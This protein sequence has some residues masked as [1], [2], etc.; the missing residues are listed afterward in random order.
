MPGY[1]PFGLVLGGL[2]AIGLFGYLI[3]VLIHPERF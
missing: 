3:F 1:D 2:S